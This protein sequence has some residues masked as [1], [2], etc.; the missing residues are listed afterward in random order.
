MKKKLFIVFLILCVLVPAT[1]SAKIFDLSLG[2]NMQFAPDFAEISGG[3]DV[4]ELFSDFSNYS[5][6]A[7]LRMK[8]LLA[9]VDVVTTFGKAAN[10]DFQIS[11]LATAGVSFDLFGF[12]RLGVGLGP[13]F[14]V[15]FGDGD[16]QVLDY[17]DTP[18]DF[19]NLGDAFIKSPLALRA[20]ADFKIGKKIWLGASYTLNTNYTFE[21]YDELDKLFNANWDSG[22]FGVSFLF[23][24]F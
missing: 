6:G 11:A 12:T 13:N 2:A 8:I 17:N 15:L 24:F 1:L 21:K 4:G 18:V 3:G 23:S 14:S 22:S 9:E 20:T 19:D 10:D 7:D 5:F 16:P